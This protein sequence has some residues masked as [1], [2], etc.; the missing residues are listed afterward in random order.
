MPYNS[1]MV[2]AN[3]PKYEA[4]LEQPPEVSTLGIIDKF[5]QRASRLVHAA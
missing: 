2:D 1:V 4:S 3:L 5:A